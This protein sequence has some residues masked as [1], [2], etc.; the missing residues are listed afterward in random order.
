LQKPTAVLLAPGI[1]SP[2]KITVKTA[3]SARALRVALRAS[4]DS[5]LTRQGIGAYQDDG[6]RPEF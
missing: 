6:S 3:R 5:G 4:L 1:L 2:R